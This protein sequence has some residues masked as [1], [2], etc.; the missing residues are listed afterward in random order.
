M[1]VAFQEPEVS[2]ASHEEP[3]IDQEGKPPSIH[4]QPLQKAQEKQ[5]E[6]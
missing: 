3:Y 2:I 4:L 6:I 1:K 5:E